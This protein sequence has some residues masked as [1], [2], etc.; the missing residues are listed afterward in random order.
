VNLRLLLSGLAQSFPMMLCDL[1]DA[2]DPAC[3]WCVW[4]K[5]RQGKGSITATFRERAGG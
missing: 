4:S 2:H 1:F 5:L 3:Q